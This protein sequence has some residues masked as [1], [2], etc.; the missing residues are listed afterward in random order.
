MRYYD[1]LKEGTTDQITVFYGGRFQ[2]MHKGHYSLYLKLV[3]EYGA[4]NVFIATTFGK[5]QQK[6]H[7]GG[8]YSTD[9]FNF[10][11]KQM[12]IS[13]MFGISKS[14]IIDTLPYR[15]D[16][17]KAG[18][19]PSKT[20]TVLAV[21]AKDADRL[22]GGGVLAPL[23]K[24]TA[25]LQTTDENRAYFT[26]LPVEEGGMSAT[27]FRQVMASN[28]PTEEKQNTFVQFFGKFDE[29]IFNFIEER[30]A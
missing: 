13:K 21:S 27:D 20:A 19:D 15:P 16:L 29:E 24:D 18:K 23:P 11:E 2:P 22:I 4:D 6:M 26:I 9:P 10:N 28:V 30:L 1:I 25:T 17:A 14:H 3:R 8:N 7:G 5:K 12:I